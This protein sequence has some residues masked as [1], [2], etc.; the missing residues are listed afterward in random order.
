MEERRLLLAVALSLVVLTAYQFLF[1]PAPPR[2]SPSR[3]VASPSAGGATAPAPVPAAAAAAPASARPVAPAVQVSAPRELG[4]DVEAPA[5]GVVFTNKG[6]RILSWKLKKFTDLQG[7]PEEMVLAVRPPP[8]AGPGPWGPRPLDLETGDA[9]LDARLRQALFVSSTETL[10]VA[11]GQDAE[12]VFRYAEGDLE[13]VKSLRFRAPGY[14]VAVQASVRRGGQRVPVK[15]LWGPGVGNPTASERAV[16]G[17]H[18][19]QAVY[20]DRDGVTRVAA[21][22]I[23]TTRA[24]PDVFWGGVEG[25]YFAALW[26]PMP[27]PGPL[28]VRTVALPASGDVPGGPAPV[29]AAPLAADGASALLFVGPKDH[30]LLSDLGYRLQGVVDVGT[31]LGPIV[32]PLLALLRWVHGHVGNYGWSIVLLTVLINLTMAPFR[33]FSIAYSRKM[34]KLAPEMKVIQERYRKYSALDPK[35]QEMQQEMAALY[36][37]HGMSMGTQM[38]VGCLP[39]LLTLPFLFAFYTVLKVAIEL[40]GAQF[41]WIHDLSQRDP[42]FVTPVLMGLS[43]VIMQRMMPSAMDPAQQR[44]MMIMP[45]VLVVMFFAAPAGLNLYWLASNVCSIIQ[46]GITLAILKRQEEAG[47]GGRK[48]RR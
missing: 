14:L 24:L 25:P 32:V 19:P 11:E 3:P 17:Y 1:P 12:L 29:A 20:V 40:R 35:R 6:A 5:V 26:V 43:M 47:G 21:E 23:G 18:P 30:R 8:E 46:Q 4:V 38:M 13:V 44:I 39:Q 22:K 15:V 2:P 33:H 16:Q 9:D 27:P 7:K 37:R 48:E 41:L 42:W 10:T 34:A 31:W 45:L 36:A 28:E